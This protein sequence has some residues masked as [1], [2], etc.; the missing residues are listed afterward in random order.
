VMPTHTLKV[1]SGQIGLSSGGQRMALAPGVAPIST[2]CDRS[3]E[4]APM[5]AVAMP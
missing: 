1:P 2:P 5:C 3:A 4:P